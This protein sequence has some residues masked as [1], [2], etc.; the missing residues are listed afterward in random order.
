MYIHQTPKELETVIIY[1]HIYIPKPFVWTGCD[2]TSIFNRSLT[3][4]KS[5]FSF[6]WIDWHTMVKEPS[7]S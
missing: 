4:L 2:I 5:E 6:S 3:G 1:I 7:L